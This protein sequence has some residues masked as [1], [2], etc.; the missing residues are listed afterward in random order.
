MR[1][2]RGEWK[3]CAAAATRGKLFVLA[4]SA[5]G[6]GLVVTTAVSLAGA[7]VVPR[8]TRLGHDAGEFDVIA[9]PNVRL[10]LAARGGLAGAGGG[11]PLADREAA[12]AA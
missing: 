1:R 3:R 5:K 2:E 10:V 8:G 6:D 9:P 4:P 12:A 7:R 11:H